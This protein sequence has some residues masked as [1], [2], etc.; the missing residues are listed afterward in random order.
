VE[1]KKLTTAEVKE[2][3]RKNHP[4]KVNALPQMMN[5]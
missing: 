4:G 1:K 3:L 2:L 5:H